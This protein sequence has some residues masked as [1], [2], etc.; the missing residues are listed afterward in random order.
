MGCVSSNLLNQ[1]DEFTQ[2]GSS[3]LGHHI[4]SLTSTTYGL[5]TLD[6]P[7]QSTTTPPTPPPPFSL[8]STFNESKSL[9][10]EPRS[11]P[12][13]PEVINS[14][15][16]M[17]GLDVDSFRFSPIINKEN[18]NPNFSK[19]DSASKPTVSRS[20]LLD[21]FQA[22]FR[23]P[24]TFPSEKE[25][26]DPNLNNNCT[27]PK[28]PFSR[29][30]LLQ[31]FNEGNDAVLEPSPLDNFEQI[32]P[33]NGENRVVI[34]TTTLRGIRKTFEDCNAV[35][36]AIESY[37][38]VICERDISMDRGFKEELR[39]LMKGQ[40]KESNQITP[41]RVFIKG[42]YIGGAEELMTIVDEGWF[43]DLI[44]GLP[45]KRAGEVCDGCGDVKFLPCFQCNG[46]CK[47]AVVVNEEGRTVV[48]RCTECNENGLVH[49][50]ICS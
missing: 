19:N 25:N 10:S 50:P 20:S 8:G 41:P 17:S 27:V 5:L 23:F 3:A 35:R 14:W 49:C 7:P 43:G 12:T 34:Y 22:S 47:M 18:P 31:K 42:R 21:K 1:D 6:P 26:A 40:D 29:S 4:V 48:V 33:P 15:E 36:S 37:G 24:N 13:R 2:L 39:E 32:C 44:K 11:V 28:P 38:L 45:K 16:L 30:S 46:S 9:W